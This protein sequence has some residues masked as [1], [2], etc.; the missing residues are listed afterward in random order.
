[1]DGKT[2]FPRA[3]RHVRDDGTSE[4]GELTQVQFKAYSR[5]N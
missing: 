2:S 3:S 1:M 4:K 5:E